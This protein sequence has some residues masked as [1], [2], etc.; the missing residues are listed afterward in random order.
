MRRNERRGGVSLK[1]FTD[2]A[3]LTISIVD[4]I[5]IDVDIDRVVNN[6]RV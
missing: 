2:N 1:T 5:N 4:D 6:Q 3:A